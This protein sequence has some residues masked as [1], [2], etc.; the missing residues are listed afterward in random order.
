MKIVIGFFLVIFTSPLFAKDYTIDHL[1]IYETSQLDPVKLTVVVGRLAQHENEYLIEFVGAAHKYHGYVFH[2]EKKFPSKVSKKINYHLSSTKR[3]PLR[4]KN[5]STFI[6]GSITPFLETYI[7]RKTV[8][9]FQAK[10]MNNMSASERDII[11]G[12]LTSRYFP[13]Q[14]LDGNRLATLSDVLKRTKEQALVTK[15]SCKKAENFSILVDGSF[16]ESEGSRLQTGGQYLQA[17]QSLCEEDIDYQEEIRKIKQL[18]FSYSDKPEP[19]NLN[20]K[21]GVLSVVLSDGQE[22][23]PLFVKKWL[24]DNL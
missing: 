21:K 1:S 4:D 7:D 2:Y 11:K 8:R 6:E 14:Q 15:K 16:P 10:R 23:T 13:S 5:Q 19:F 22:N 20:L 18:A 3:V 24:E 9:L 17:M 12:D